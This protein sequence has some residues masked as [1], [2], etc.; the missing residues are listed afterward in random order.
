[1]LAGCQASDMN[2]HNSISACCVLFAVSLA[3][4]SN[5]EMNS[6][7]YTLLLSCVYEFVDRFSS[8]ECQ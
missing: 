5:D 7:V 3:I 4:V 1:M 8:F 2:C 6:R